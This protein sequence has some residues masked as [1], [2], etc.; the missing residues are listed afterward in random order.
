VQLSINMFVSVAVKC[1]LPH[2]LLGCSKWASQRKLMLDEIEELESAGTMVSFGGL[3]EEGRVIAL[4]G[5]KDPATEFRFACW[6]GHQSVGRAG[7]WAVATFLQSVNAE[8]TRDLQTIIESRGPKGYGNLLNL[9]QPL[10]ET[11][12]PLDL[13]SS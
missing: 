13:D 4:L 10:R 9:S 2:I 3:C 8:F 1:D 7:F 5:G 6:R 11:E 12:E